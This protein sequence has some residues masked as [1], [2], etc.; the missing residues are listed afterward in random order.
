MREEGGVVVLDEVLVVAFPVS[1]YL[2]YWGCEHA[3]VHN[4]KVLSWRARGTTS[5]TSITATEGE[6]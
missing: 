6:R 1:S 2:I 3:V 4:A 5:V